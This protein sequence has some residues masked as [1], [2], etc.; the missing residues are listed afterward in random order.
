M[1]MQSKV[2]YQGQRSSEVKLKDRLKIVKMVSFEKLKSNLKKKSPAFFN[3][4][5]T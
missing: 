3:F 1:F 5:Q 2:I 4:N